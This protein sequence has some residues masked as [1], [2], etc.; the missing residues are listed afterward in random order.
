MSRNSSIIA[1][2]PWIFI[3][4]MGVT[5]SGKSTFIRTASGDESIV[6]G[7]SLKSCTSELRGYSFH[8]G[9]YNIT[10]VDSPGFNDTYKSEAEVL[11]DIAEWLRESYE[12]KTKLSGI[13]YLHSIKNERM[14]GSALRNLRMFRELCGDEPLKNVI[15][16]TSFWDDVLRN[17][18]EKREEELRTEFWGGMIRRGSRTDRF[19]GRAS[20]LSIILSL[21][22]KKPVPLEIQCE[23][24]EQRKPLVETAA[25]I[26]V[27]E[28]LAR[29]EAKHKREREQLQREMQEALEARDRELQGI[30]QEQRQKLDEELDRVHRQQEMMKAE[31][32]ADRRR[33][34]Y[35]WEDFKRLQSQIDL[36]SPSSSSSSSSSPPTAIPTSSS[37]NSHYR[38]LSHPYQIY[39]LTRPPPPTT[40]PIPDDFDWIVSIMRANESKIKPEERVV[41]E[42]KIQEAMEKGAETKGAKGNGKLQ[43][44][45]VGQFLLRSLQV[46][47]PVTTMAL[48]G[49]PLHLPGDLFG[50]SGGS[51]PEAG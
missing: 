42:L 38:S 12:A 30:L 28:E 6:I 23:L 13:I 26:A 18:A 22:K 48:L 20:A 31:R 51:G 40:A 16:V 11:G 25:G 34:E 21:T 17:V 35:Q 29:L 44:K 37:Y 47:L 4:V 45:K 3:A 2:A 43:K 7:H 8:H 1:D 33:M 41:L 50:G 49:F 27:N 14:E 19:Q 5:G 39:Q 32:R 9:G 15:L 46:V 36:R 10:L 24:V